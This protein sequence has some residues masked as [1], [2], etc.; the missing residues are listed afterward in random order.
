LASYD[1]QSFATDQIG[2]SGVFTEKGKIA[3]IGVRV[4]RGITRHGISINISNDISLFQ[5]IRSCGVSQPKIDLLANYQSSVVLAEAF[6]LWFKHFT[7]H[8]S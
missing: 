4:D 7:S 3:F 5:N 1:V 8:I 6:E 2:Q